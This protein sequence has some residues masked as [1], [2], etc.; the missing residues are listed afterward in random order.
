[1]TI[2]VEQR[3]WQCRKMLLHSAHAGKQLR[4]TSAHSLEHFAPILILVEHLPDGF[5]DRPPCNFLHNAGNM[6][7]YPRKVCFEPRTLPVTCVQLCVAVNSAF[8]IVYADIVA[9]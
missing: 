9:H 1:M 6:C 4:F 7:R 8:D 5:E 2:T 3:L